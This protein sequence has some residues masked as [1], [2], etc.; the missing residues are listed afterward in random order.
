MAGGLGFAD[1]L[2]KHLALITLENTPEFK[3]QNQ[4]YLNLLFS[5]KRHT[6]V[7]LNDKGAEGHRRNVIIKARQRYDITQTDTV[8]SC[9]NVLV[10]TYFERTVAL[11]GFRQIALYIDDETIALYPKEASTSVG[12]GQPGTTMMDEF[13]TSIKTA[14][15]AILSGV[16]QDLFTLGAA[17]IGINVRTGNAAATGINLRLD[18]TN[19]P[20]NQGMTQVL[21]DYTQNQSSG[22]PKMVG[23][24]LPNNYFIQQKAKSSDQSGF[25]TPIMANDFDFFYDPFAATALGANEA[26]VYEPEA[27]QIVEYM[28]YKGF[29]G[30][31]KQTSFF[32]TFML[33]IQLSD[34]V[35]Q[36][37]FDA[38]LKYYD[39]PQTLTDAYYD[40]SVTVDKGWSIIISKDFGLFTIDQAYRGTDLLTGNRGSLR[41]G[42]T[43]V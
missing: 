23:S 31:D 24:G 3:L 39:C 30:G 33:P 37:E 1:S 2:T 6:E 41:Y 35:A 27:V 10:P 32:F 19:N 17:A 4:G 34:R 43:N 14:A 12:I 11:P 21:S 5:N 29:K 40:T 25:S 15:D 8:H 28:R 7:K 36:V 13:V 38:Q 42:F 26:I 22:K 16:N 9:D 18:T 20:L